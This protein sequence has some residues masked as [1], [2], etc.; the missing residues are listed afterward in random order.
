MASG[1][2]LAATVAHAQGGGQPGD[3]GVLLFPALQP[4][5]AFCFVT[6]RYAAPPRAPSAIVHMG[7]WLRPGS[8]GAAAALRDPAGYAAALGSSDA[9]PEGAEEAG[10][11]ADAAA[12]GVAGAVADAAGAAAA[13]AECHISAPWRRHCAALHSCG[14]LLD[15]AVRRALRE[16]ARASPAFAAVALV[17]G[18]GNHAPTGP[19]SVEYSGG[20]PGELL[21]EFM[22]A[23]TRAARALVAEGAPTAVVALAGKG[24]V[25][26]LLA[27]AAG[28][29]GAGAGAGEARGLCCEALRGMDFG[30]F[31]EGRQLRL[32]AVGG[33]F[34]V[35]PCGGT[36][37][38]SAAQL[39]QL[40]IGKVTSKKGVTK[41]TYTCDP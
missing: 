33:A 24:E 10:E 40:V 17:G 37:V 11:A 23:L 28:A 21:G 30:G 13:T 5:R 4:P 31:A 36:H 9:A 16:L 35:C 12:A 27:E 22:A 8:A 39:A 14:H 41:I 3:R 6:A 7:W 1:V 29:G 32:V 20:V 25:A 19:P 2:I 34:N 15:G 26:G 38:K 18:K